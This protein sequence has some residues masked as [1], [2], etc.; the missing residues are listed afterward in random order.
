MRSRFVISESDRRSILSMYGLLNEQT[1][2]TINGVVRRSADY[3]KL[4]NNT[5]AP[6]VKVSL[7]KINTS[8]GFDEL[9][10]INTQETNLNG[11]FS[12]TNLD[13]FE[14]LMIGTSEN[15]FYKRKEINVPNKTETT[16]NITII[17]NFKEGKEPLEGEEE[18]FEEPC[19]EYISDEKT[20]YGKAKSEIFDPKSDD[21]TYDQVVI[22]AK[23][24]AL[25]NYLKINFV[26]SARH[27]ELIEKIKNQDS[28]KYKIVCSERILNQQ[29]ISV[30]YITVKIN[31][32]D[33]DL[34]TKEEEVIAP[35][36]ETRINFQKI[37]FREL[38]KKSKDENK[39]SF[40]LLTNLNEEVSD[41]LISR[42]NSNIDIVNKL[43]NNYICVNY[44][45]DESDMNG[46]ISA[47]NNLGVYT[48]PSLI[49]LKGTKDPYPI[50]GSF[51]VS[52]KI[53][54]FSDYFND[55]DN[56]INRIN[57]LIK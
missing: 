19:Q 52:T 54:D 47:S 48:I 33:L 2:K 26:I 25:K 16:Q 4:V 1:K 18:I 40:I 42:L 34:F 53:T 27:P 46:Y 35:P 55:L 31:K 12:F 7:Y 22:D 17:I 37:G 21:D 30:K 11:E 5:P 6:K 36:V 32:E 8:D 41:D 24:D 29:N 10:L 49:I 50:D 28:I 39:E 57:N 20:F 13:S 15:D 45:N 44:I 9:V 43:N 3:N 14:N 38:I 51:K 23:I 56:Y